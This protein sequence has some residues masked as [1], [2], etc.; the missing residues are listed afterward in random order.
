MG[1]PVPGGMWGSGAS[2][3]KAFSGPIRLLPE[4]EHVWSWFPAPATT[5]K[6]PVQK[7]PDAAQTLLVLTVS[8]GLG[9]KSESAAFLSKDALGLSV[10]S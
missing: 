8:N 1:P 2:A 5:S 10:V 4:V 3:P 9:E 7:Q 6:A